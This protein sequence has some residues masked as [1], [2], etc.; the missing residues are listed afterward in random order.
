MTKPRTREIGSH[1]RQALRDLALGRE[2]AQLLELALVLPF[3]LV[4]IVGIL[5]FGGAYNLKQKLNNA[6]R[7]G[8]RFAAGENSGMNLQTSDV[9]AIQDVMNTY[10]TNAGVTQC[11]IDATPGVAGHVYT[12]QSMSTGCGGFSLVIDRNYLVTAGSTT[13]GATHVTLTYPYTWSLG[14]VIKLI[15]PAS[16]L[17][18]PATISTDSI[19]RNIN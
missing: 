18:L 3:L 17:S 15:L 5:D 14:N 10:L 8:A 16:T 11:A 9:Q 4:M 13:V 12:F 6:A 2:G 1:I 19:M 7:E